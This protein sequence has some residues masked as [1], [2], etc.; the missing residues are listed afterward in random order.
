MEWSW[1]DEGYLELVNGAADLFD[2][3][4][5]DTLVYTNKLLAVTCRPAGP[6]A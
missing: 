4:G 1:T 5:T 6:P 2:G 3:Y